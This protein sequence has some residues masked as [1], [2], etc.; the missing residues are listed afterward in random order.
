M[1]V[2]IKG[3]I[4]KSAN[5]NAFN[6]NANT[7]LCSFASHIEYEPDRAKPSTAFNVARFFL[8]VRYTMWSFGI[9]AHVYSDTNEIIVL[10]LYAKQ[11]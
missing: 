11:Y 8:A 7:T 6:T 9:M 2:E 1:N 3:P 5:A 4:L 10:C